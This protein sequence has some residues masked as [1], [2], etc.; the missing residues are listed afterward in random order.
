MAARVRVRR[1]SA[2]WQVQSALVFGLSLYCH[3]VTIAYVP[4]YICKRMKLIGME[5]LSCELWRNEGRIK[6]DSGR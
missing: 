3:S 6:D 4:S 5:G 2:P 1:H